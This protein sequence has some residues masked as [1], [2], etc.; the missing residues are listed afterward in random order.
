MR[1]KSP[2]LR[3]GPVTIRV[4]GP[5]REQFRLFCILENGTDAELRFADWRNFCSVAWVRGRQAGLRFDT[6]L[7]VE[8]M[9]ELR[10]IAE[11]RAEWDRENQISAA[12]AWSGGADREP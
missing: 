8:D 1:V 2:A 4:T 12:R 9:E 3:P 5:G 6:L 7:S 11:N 10:W